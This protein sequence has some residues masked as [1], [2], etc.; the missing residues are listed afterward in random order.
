MRKLTGE[1]IAGVW[2]QTSVDRVKTLQRPPAVF[3]NWFSD[4]SGVAASVVRSKAFRLTVSNGSSQILFA[5][6]VARWNVFML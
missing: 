2:R 4:A 5:R 3:G 1:P 6:E